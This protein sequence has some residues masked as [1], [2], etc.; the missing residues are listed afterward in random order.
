MPTAPHQKRRYKGSKAHLIPRK[1]PSFKAVVKCKTQTRT[2]KI[3]VNPV[4]AQKTAHQSN[5]HRHRP[6]LLR[7]KSNN[8]LPLI[9]RS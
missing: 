3:S 2:F 7:C 6:K 4:A 8:R 5:L 9:S 1:N